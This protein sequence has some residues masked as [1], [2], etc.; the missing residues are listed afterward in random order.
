VCWQEHFL[1]SQILNAVRVVGISWS[2]SEILRHLQRSDPVAF[3]KL[4]TQVIGNWIDRT[5]PVPVWKAW[6][7]KRAYDGRERGIVTRKSILAPYPELNKEIKG[8]LLKLWQGGIAMDTN[9]SR[10]IIVANFHFR[11]PEI[12]MKRAKD[13]SYFRCTDAWVKKYLRDNLNWSFRRATRAAQK[14]PPNIDEIL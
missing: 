3:K 10:G 14:V 13:G 8:Q 1:W 4:T 2:P 12:F 9:R 5:G 7:L 11:A 6:V